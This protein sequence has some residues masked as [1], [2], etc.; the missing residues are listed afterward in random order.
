MFANLFSSD[1][2]PFILTLTLAILSWFISNIVSNISDVTVVSIRTITGGPNAVYEI[3]NYSLKASMTD[4]YFRF[5]CRS[6]DCFVPLSDAGVA[7]NY[8]NSRSVPPYAVQGAQICKNESTGI[9]ARFSLPPGSKI[10]FETRPTN[11][12]DVDVVF[13][14][15]ASGDGIPPCPDPETRLAPANVWIYT[16]CSFTLFFIRYYFAIL[17]TLLLASLGFLIFLLLR[18]PAP[19]AGAGTTPI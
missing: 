7:K 14:G 8:A 5:V 1:K 18:P 3:A 9:S 13:A 17:V 6:K 2:A 16:G 10:Q 11:R 19:A 4:A 15:L 12:R